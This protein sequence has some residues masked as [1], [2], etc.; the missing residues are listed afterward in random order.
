MATKQRSKMVVLYVKIP[1]DT[2][3]S[4][5]A[6]AEHED[7]SRS[8]IVRRAI[9]FYAAPGDRGKAAERKLSRSA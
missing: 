7:R 8:S 3:C 9:D 1:V 5:D 6:C 4:L 2:L